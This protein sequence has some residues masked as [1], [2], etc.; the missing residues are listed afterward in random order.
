MKICRGRKNRTKSA[1]PL[2]TVMTNPLT[3]ETETESR[4][5]SCGAVSGKKRKAYEAEHVTAALL[6]VS[7]GISIKKAAAKWNVPRSSLQYMLKTGNEPMSRPG[8]AT[9]LTKTEEQLLADWLIELSRRGIPINKKNLL[10]SVQGIIKADGRPNPF[11]NDRPG[12]GWFHAFLQRNPRVGERTAESISRGRGA[13]TEGCIRGWFDDAKK[14]FEEKCSYVLSDPSKQYNAD[15]TGFQMDPKTGRIL[16]PRG[17]VAYT[18]SG[19]SKE[20]ISVLITTRADGKVMQSCI[21]YP[22]KRAVPKAIIDSVPA[23]FCIARSDSGWMTSEVFYE[24]LAN[25]F[26]PELTSERR[27]ARGLGEGEDLELTDADWVVLWIDGYSSHLQI[28]TS[29]LCDKHK[30]VLYCF[31][32]HASHICQP[33]DVGPF[34]PLKHEWKLAVTAWRMEHPY[35]Q[36][37]KVAFAPL[38]AKAIE[39]L[40]KSSIIAGYKATGLFPFDAEAIHYERL[41]ATNRTKYDE[42]AF[43]SDKLMLSDY[44]TALRCMEEV[45]GKT[46]LQKYESGMAA[47]LSA[48]DVWVRI[49]QRS[50]GTET[51]TSSCVSADHTA[52]DL[53]VSCDVPNAVNDANQ[54][55][56]SGTTADA[57]QQVNG[58]L[59][60]LHSGTSGVHIFAG[61][62]TT[63]STVSRDVPN[64]VNDA[65]QWIASGTTADAGQQVNGFLPPL[66]NNVSAQ[67]VII[68]TTRDILVPVSDASQWALNDLGSNQYTSTPTSVEDHTGHLHS[69]LSASEDT[70]IW[71]N[72]YMVCTFSCT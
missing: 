10:D 31:K 45:I 27:S 66:L 72:S 16:A 12:K 67:P 71:L 26:I 13:L 53:A 47:S 14:F 63:A 30:I 42:H 25:T 15:E 60:P 41:T 34:K 32:A 56:A 57:G 21:V 22:Y 8:P 29:K 58:F 7:L 40:D 1:E 64:A 3:E 37:T 49:K 70:S 17:E 35:E 5:M 38:L 9:I 6:D 65:N 61:D 19:G 55:M 59:Q 20:Q 33:N 68:N 50:C 43:G 51:A 11:T 46:E 24:Y 69:S 44:K 39:N 48:F 4:P 52:S 2:V 18:E 62:T 28:H 54:W 36:L 23:G